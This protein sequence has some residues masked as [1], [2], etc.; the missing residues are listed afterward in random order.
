[1]RRILSSQDG[2][3]LIIAL[4]VI[5]VQALLLTGM[6]ELAWSAQ[7]AARARIVRTQL[8]L[9]ASS[10]AR[11]HHN[12]VTADIFKDKLPQN[13]LD[14]GCKQQTADFRGCA[15][16]GND[17]SGTSGIRKDRI[18]YFVNLSRLG[19]NQAQIAFRDVLLQVMPP[20]P[21]YN[22]YRTPAVLGYGGYEFGGTFAPTAG[23]SGVRVPVL[24]RTYSHAYA[25]NYRPWEFSP[26]P[27]A[28]ATIYFDFA[29]YSWARPATGNQR[30]ERWVW[31][32]TM[33][34]RESVIFLRYPDCPSNFTLDS[35][36][37][38]P[39]Y[40][41]VSVSTPVYII[42]EPG[43]TLSPWDVRP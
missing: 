24:W 12:L 11:W 23:G 33:L 25:S 38:Y 28:S 2:Y 6:M 30:E 17:W 27:P 16:S 14:Q 43:V 7:Q 22:P 26:G 4:A 1:V 13:I 18:Q 9:A 3:A 42:S 41:S 20:A 15:V 31:Q 5:L 10:H 37:N 39:E 32:V 19:W 8:R 21:E 35:V 40:V 34:S 36:C 29:V